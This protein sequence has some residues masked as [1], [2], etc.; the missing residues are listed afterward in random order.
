MKR[1]VATIALAILTLATLAGCGSSRNRSSSGTATWPRVATAH[2]TVI[3][4]P[5]IDHAQVARYVEEGFA[6]ARTRTRDPEGR[7][8]IHTVEGVTIVLG[9]W[10]RYHGSVIEIL[11]GTEFSIA[12]EIQHL[13]A[14]R[15]GL[16]GPCLR[17][18]DHPDDNPG[19]GCNL[20][21]EWSVGE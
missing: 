14:Q 4:G 7:V 10:S 1:T 21:G 13:L 11:Q 16:K 12:H 20:D 3:V 15:N 8:D 17:F 9:T 6:R 5:G 19:G 18:Q 2:G